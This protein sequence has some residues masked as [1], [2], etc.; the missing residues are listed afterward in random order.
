MPIGWC[1]LEKLV[2]EHRPTTGER[3]AAGCCSEKPGDGCRCPRTSDKS[4]MHGRGDLMI[5]EVFSGESGPV[6][7]GGVP[8]LAE[9][10]LRR[11]TAAR[12]GLRYPLTLHG[13]HQAC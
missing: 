10:R 5:G 4:S 12:H 7:I 13:V 2:P 11:C 3:V 8:W 9:N 1:T 6:C